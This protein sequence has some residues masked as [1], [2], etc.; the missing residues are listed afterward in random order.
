MKK[1][2][3]VRV[4]EYKDATI[5]TLCLDDRPIAVTLEDKWRDNEKMVSCI[6]TGT[7]TITIHNSP[8]FGRCYKVLDVPG[9]SEIL[10]HAGNT[11]KDT[12]GCIL[13]GLMHGTVGT[14]TA[15]LS[16]RAAVD[17]FMTMMLGVDKATL[18]IVSAV[19]CN[20]A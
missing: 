11:H 18:T 2:R 15:I 19:E 1:L 12:H 5:G 20:D 4:T 17:N 8:K 6:P 10:I 7:Y 13:L 14:E 9:R 16:S 3:L